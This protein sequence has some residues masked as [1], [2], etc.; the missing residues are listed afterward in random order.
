MADRDASS[1]SSSFPT[2]SLILFKLLSK[3]RTWACLFLLVYTVLIS[4]SWNL[5]L[6][7][8]SWYASN[9]SSS[10]FPALYASVLY[11][12]VFGLISMGA[13]LAVAVPATVVTWITVLV[14]LTFFG[15]PRSAL[16]EEARKATKDIASLAIR[17]LLKEGNLAA[18]V[19]AVAS[20]VALILKRSGAGENNGDGDL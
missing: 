2:W 18:I 5:L 3:R 19:C 10:P 6:S 12:L 9:N 8:R 4:S 15:K 16:V 20:F 17:V 11:G 13:A 1:E 7:I 14:L